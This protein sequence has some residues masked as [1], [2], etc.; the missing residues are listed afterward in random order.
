[1]TVT[2]KHVSSSTPG[3][4][5]I[6]GFGKQK[7]SRSRCRPCTASHRP[8]PRCLRALQR[9]ARALLLGVGAATPHRLERALGQRHLASGLAQFRHRQAEWR[10]VAGGQGGSAGAGATAVDGRQAE[11]DRPRQAWATHPPAGPLVDVAGRHGCA[12]LGAEQGLFVRVLLAQL[13]ERRHAVL[14]RGG[15]AGERVSAAQWRWSARACRRPFCDLL[16]HLQCA[17]VP[18]CWSSRDGLVSA[19]HLDGRAERKGLLGKV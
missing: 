2:L 19:T 5:Y 13:L 11:S 9:L 1:M 6:P 15:Q 17:S 14:L 7:I 10:G 12:A 18:N 3:L 4:A 8:E 16:P